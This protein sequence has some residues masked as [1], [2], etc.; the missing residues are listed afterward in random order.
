LVRFNADRP[1]NPIACVAAPE[2]VLQ[3]FASA[4]HATG[5]WQ[6]RTK[7]HSPKVRKPHNAAFKRLTEGDEA[8]R[9]QAAEAKAQFKAGARRAGEAADTLTATEKALKEELAALSRRFG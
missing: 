3:H 5:K 2:V 4:C 6:K 8:L 7:I 9:Q 1:P